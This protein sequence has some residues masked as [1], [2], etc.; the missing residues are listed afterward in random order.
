MKETPE[1]FKPRRDGWFEHTAFWYEVAVGTVLAQRDT[2]TQAWEVIA[3][4]HG[5]EPIP[6]NSTLWLRLKNTKSGD[7]VTIPPRNKY[8][9]CVI[10]NH[11]PL[12][13][14]LETPVVPTDAEA[15]ATLVETLGASHLAT[16]DD[17]SGIVW[18]PDYVWNSHID[19]AEPKPLTRGLLEHLAFAHNLIPG[20]E[21]DTED[22]ATVLTLHGEQ[23]RRTGNMAAFAHAHLPDEDTTKDW[24][25]N[26]RAPDIHA[27]RSTA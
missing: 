21:V 17:A 24:V 1:D 13:V 19:K 27:P 9:T 20:A 7:E 2:R 14:S 26:R 6:F 22:Y 15:V 12:D 8:G 3:T 4:A 5:T 25:V 10:L 18:C 23:H 16:K 11:D